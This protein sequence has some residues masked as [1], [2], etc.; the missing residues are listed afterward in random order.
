MNYIKEF[1]KY[2]GLINDDIYHKKIGAQ[3]ILFIG[4]CRCIVYSILFEEICK[5]VPYFIRGQFGFA[6]VAVHIINLLNRQK[7][8]N[9]KYIIEN[10]DYIVCEQTRKYSFLNSSTNCEQNIFNNFKIKD[11][12]KILQIPNLELKYYSNDLNYKNKEDINNIKQENLKKFI[13]H[14]KKYEFNNLC[15][16]IENNINNERL[17]STSNHP[18]NNLLLELFKELIQ[19]IFGQQLEE[20]VLNILRNVRIF[21]DDVNRTNINEIDYQTGLS[22]NIN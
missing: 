11:N 14:C 13:E 5:N 9:L 1:Q 19:K 22:R 21:D 20:S 4:G 7:T 10:A 12:C 3:N 18:C 8:N 6:T 17:F 15:T 16:Y 2:D